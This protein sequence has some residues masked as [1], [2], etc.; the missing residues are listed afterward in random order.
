MLLKD[1][2]HVLNIRLNLISTGRL[3]DEGY[4]MTKVPVV[5]SK[6]HMEIL[7]GKPDCGMCPE[8]KYFICDACTTKVERGK[9]GSR[10][11]Q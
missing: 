3:D 8:A 9:H 1:V 11:N 7:Q 2:R 4:S 10:H 6:W 5:T